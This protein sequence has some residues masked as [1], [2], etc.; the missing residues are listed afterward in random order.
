MLDMGCKRH[1]I[2][3]THPRR[4]RVGVPAKTALCQTG[5]IIETAAQFKNDI[6]DD[7]TSTTSPFV[8][9]AKKKKRV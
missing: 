8:C 4:D 2:N 6:Q 7:R 3:H 5:F 1:T 9:N